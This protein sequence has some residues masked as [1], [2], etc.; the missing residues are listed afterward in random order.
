MR[1]RRSGPK[2]EIFIG[3]PPK[4][5]PRSSARTVSRLGAA[6]SRS[7]LEV[8]LAGSR[9]TLVLRT[10]VRRSCVL[11]AQTRFLA[12]TAIK[13]HLGKKR[14]TFFTNPKRTRTVLLVLFGELGQRWE[15]RFFSCL[16]DANSNYSFD[17]VF[18][19]PPPVGGIGSIQYTGSS[20]RG[21]ARLGGGAVVPPL[22][23]VK[24]C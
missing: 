4:A 20:N 17:V 18:R 19:P 24:D 7:S 5:T 2:R 11:P 21:C 15:S 10:C 8:N 16:S 9:G 13:Y 6:N 22:G 1:W 14:R 12:E 23:V 3:S